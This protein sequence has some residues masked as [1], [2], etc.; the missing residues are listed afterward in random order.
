MTRMSLSLLLVAA[1][2]GGPPPAPRETA[3]TSAATVPADNA[4]EA[5]LA[6]ARARIAELEQRSN[7]PVA[8]A[9]PLPVAAPVVPCTIELL[10]VNEP[11]KVAELEGKYRTERQRFVDMLAGL[12]RVRTQATKLPR[13]PAGLPS[14]PYFVLNFVGMPATC[15]I[16]AET[17]SDG[18]YPW[19]TC[20][21]E[22][23]EDEERV[24]RFEGS[25]RHLVGLLGERFAFVEHDRQ[26][27]TDEAVPE[28]PYSDAVNFFTNL[29][30]ST[31]T[32]GDEYRGTE[33]GVR[34]VLL[35]V[36][37]DEDKLKA[38]GTWVAPVA[39]KLVPDAKLPQVRRLVAD[40]W[41]ASHANM[42]DLAVA[43]EQ[44]Q[45]QYLWHEHKKLEGLFLRRWIALGRAQVATD[46][47][48]AYRFWLVRAAT[49]LKMEQT[50]SWA[51]ELAGDLAT[52]N[53][54][55][56]RAWYL[57]ELGKFKD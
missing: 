39:L 47:I 44:P 30:P 21:G 19:A 41:F 29:L 12:E 36:M 32:W 10:R 55:K 35:D 28:D 54:L 43:A 51:G 15:P 34:G 45:S 6:K 2:C 11:D 56:H 17:N 25:W 24:E 49:I 57:T 1:A 42:R 7:T 53:T 40:L 48:L 3:T 33:S 8:P 14:L 38:A 4:C 20:M 27:S 16:T 5:E 22:G 31:S 46:M 52:V 18:C 37:H 9:D 26:P 50:A 13:E 23:G